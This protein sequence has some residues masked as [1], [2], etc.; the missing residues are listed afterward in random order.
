[1]TTFSNLLR[2]PLFGRVLRHIQVHHSPSVM[3]ENDED[4]QHS[5]LGLLGGTGL[6]CRGKQSEQGNEDRAHWCV[7]RR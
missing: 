7:K 2:G 1:V 3:G 6:K 4:E 5:D